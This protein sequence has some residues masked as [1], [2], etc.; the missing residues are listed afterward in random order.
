MS[1][2]LL[3]ALLCASL[4]SLAACARTAPVPEPGA[5]RSDVFA[6]ACANPAPQIAAVASPALAEALRGLAA[7]I[8]S[9]RQAGALASVAV[10]V[11]QD[12]TTLFAAGFGCANVER[13]I[14][15]TPDTVYRVGSVTQLFEAT[16]LMQLRDA[17]RL[18]LDDEVARSVPDVWYHDAAGAKVS[19]TWRQLAS[20]TSGLPGPVPLGLETVSHLFRYLQSRRAATKPGMQYAYSELGYVVLGQSLAR[21]ARARYHELIR[22]NLLGPLGMAATTYA[23]E[24]VDPGRLAVG[25]KRLDFADS[26]WRGKEAGYK[27]RFPPSGSILSTISD[28]CRFLALQLRDGPRDG[29]LVLASASVREMRQP[30]APLGARGG[31]V[32]IGWFVHPTGR[33]TSLRK[34]GGLPGFTARLELVPERRLAVVAFVNETPRLERQRRHGVEQIERMIL[35]RLLPVTAVPPQ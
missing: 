4:G 20:H 13:R 6:P 3:G 11:V 8:E 25:Y 29:S 23:V 24:S 32:A 28:M 21:V 19:P 17:G 30:V 26:D 31:S 9:E 14:P 7:S 2:F 22:R 33:Y 18:R 15:A 12:Q 27:N 5:S 10:G 34:A 16:A 1:R 35:A